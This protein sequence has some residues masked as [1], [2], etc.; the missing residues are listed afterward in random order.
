[1][2]EIGEKPILWHIMKIFAAH[3]IDEFIVCCGY[4]GEMIQKY[5]NENN[6]ESWDIKTVDT[7]LNTMTG[8]RIKRIEELVGN[9]TFC[10]SYGDDLKNVDGI[11]AYSIFQLPFD[12]IK[13]NEILSKVLKLKKTIYFANEDFKISNKSEAERVKTIWLLKKTLNNCPDIRNYGKIKKF[14]F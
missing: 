5:F 2:I 3:K 8:G 10:L 6:S 9:E 13:R 12:D 1:M 14:C 4:K 7:G 11:V